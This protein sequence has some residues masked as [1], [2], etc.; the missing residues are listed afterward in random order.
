MFVIVLCRYHF[1]KSQ[2]N[3]KLFVIYN[4]LE[5]LDRLACAFGHDILDAFL[6]STSA[7]FTVPLK[8]V[9]QPRSVVLA[10]VHFVV[11]LAYMA[12][13][14]AIYFLQFTTL[15]VAFISSSTTLLTVL[16]SNNFM[17][18]KGYKARDL[19]MHSVYII[20]I[21]PHGCSSAGMSVKEML[22]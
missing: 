7:L 13:H 2:H 22:R 1:I 17:E 21:A 19:P 14:S 15:N 8:R 9:S 10:M 3:F 20:N 6:S 11:A 16:V 18:L 5:V 12:L 4:L